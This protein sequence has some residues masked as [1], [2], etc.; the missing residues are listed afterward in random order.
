MKKATGKLRILAAL[1]ALVML[2][3]FAGCG[4]RGKTDLQ[5]EPPI[6]QSGDGSDS[7]LFHPADIGVIPQKI[8]EYPCMGLTAKLTDKLL[9][10]MESQDVVLMTDEKYDTES[11]FSY[12]VMRWY[13]LT[14]EQKNEEVEAF[15]PDAW[16]KT[17]KKVGVLGAYKPE[18]AEK[19][20]E[21]TGCTQHTEL[22][23]SPDGKYVYY[24]SIPD[25]ADSDLTQELQKTEISLTEV[26]KLD[27]PN[28]TGVFSEV[29]SETSSTGNFTTKDINGNEFT[30]DYFKNYDLTLVNV[31]TT[32]CSFCIQEMPALERLNREMSGSGVGVLGV[33]YDSVD[34]N[35]KPVY[36]TIGLAKAIQERAGTTFPFIQPDETYMNGALKGVNS[37]PTTFF[38]DKNGNIVGEPIMGARSFEEWK[39]TVNQMLA[40]LS[41]AQ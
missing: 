24:M 4:E 5:E 30:Q 20:D 17:L 21:I 11:T 18:T 34:A 12:A 8:Y 1:M 22:G 10:K 38:I 41:Q 3:A 13:S 36:E 25:E 40:Q 32:W 16:S 33:V 15:D 9:S 14:E 26:H 7:V 35:G 27:L 2:S 37:Y 23:K 29:R 28:G 39:N 31:F 19:L 6:Y